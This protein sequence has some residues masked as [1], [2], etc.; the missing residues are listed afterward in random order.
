M[1]WILSTK[2]WYWKSEDY[3]NLY[4]T[5][6]PCISVMLKLCWKVQPDRVWH[7][8]DTWATIGVS[9]SYKQYDRGGICTPISVDNSL[10]L[11]K[12][13]ALYWTIF[14]LWNPSVRYIWGNQS[15]DQWGRDHPLRGTGLLIDPIP[16]YFASVI[17]LNF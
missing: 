7:D 6:L 16:C 11:G 2:W 3:N 17:W 15:T 1:D 5:E 12:C 13:R 9:N 8:N 14:F 4:F 10:L